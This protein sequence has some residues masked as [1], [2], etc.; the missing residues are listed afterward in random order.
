[1]TEARTPP[2]DSGSLGRILVVE[3]ERIVALDL[4]E[5]LSELGY[6]VVGTASTGEQAVEKTREQRPDLVLMDIRLAGELDGV[7]AAEQIRSER[8]VPI[9]YLTA[10]SDDETLRRAVS[11]SPLGYLVK[12]F[13]SAA[14]RCAIEIAL[15]RREI[16]SS[17]RQRE[18]WLTHTLRS[19]CDA[20][21]T[22]DAAER[23]TFLNP[24]AEAL[25]GWSNDEAVGRTLSDILR[26][27]E[28]TT[29]EGVD[30]PIRRALADGGTTVLLEEGAVLVPR[31]GD[32]IQI[33][34]SVAPI[35]GDTG[36]LVGGVMVFRAT[37]RTASV[38]EGTRRR[39]EQIEQQVM[40][41]MEQL[42][43][44]N[45]ELETFSYS[46]AHDLRAPLRGIE[47]F[48][49]ILVEDHASNLG[50]EG[51][52][53]LRRI[54]RAALRMNELIEDLLKLA[55]VAHAHLQR[56]NVDISGLAAAVCE[57][58]RSVQSGR[59]VDVLIAPDLSV[60]GDP[61]LLRIVLENLLGNAWK[62]S[63]LCEH[64]VIE[65]GSL[66]KG[67]ASEPVIFVRDNGAGFAA[68][69]AHQLFRA[70]RRFHS[71]DQFEGTGLGLS[72]V[73]R[74]VERHGG[75]IWAESE[76]GQGATFFFTLPQ[77]VSH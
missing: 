2:S 1:M 57:V 71:Q 38:E 39:N 8:E 24:V 35:L 40:A 6:A 15:H 31:L 69:Q 55:R 4:A 45:R 48:S 59:Q 54:R 7:Q 68:S 20:V 63:G 32:A 65:V 26:V 64:A 27:V 11:T 37:G 16:D 74:I 52:A 43:L 47:G 77:E 58:L 10:H 28:E 22:T 61:R 56:A 19:I 42:E 53:H 30:S 12:P 76:V 29:G 5:T 23:V 14:L 33:E 36:D 60:V 72:I 25:T 17:L 18:R 46:V 21:V 73:Q 75:R 44:A 34:D 66:E 51:L 50:P 3:D 13:N 49:Q 41:R 62:Y 67:G 9:V 70:F